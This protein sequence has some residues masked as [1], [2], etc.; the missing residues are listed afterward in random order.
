MEWILINPEGM[1]SSIDRARIIT[2]ELYNIS[3]PVFLQ[4]DSEKDYKL[5]LHVDTQHVIQVHDSCTLEKLTAVFPELTQDER[6]ALSSAI[7]QLPQITFGS[8][9]PSSV[10]V[11]D[12][13]YMIDNG[14]IT[15]DDE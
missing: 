3:R 1:L 5:A 6:F 10:T 13:Q 7:H 8:M 9:L 4:Q 15:E 2:R 12:L 14:W 11:R